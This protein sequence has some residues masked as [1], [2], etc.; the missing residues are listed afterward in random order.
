[1]LTFQESYEKCQTISGDNEAATLVLFKQDINL[2]NKR[3]NAA[4]NNY[5][6]RVSKSAN[7]VADQ[8]YY[9]LPPDCIRVIGV[10]FVLNVDRRMPLRQIRSEYQ[11]RQ[12]NFIQQS[13]NWLVYYFVK[14]ADEVGLYPT[15][16]DNLSNGV[17]IYYEP[18]G[19]ELSQADFT[20]GTVTV[21]NGS[22]TVTHS[23]TDFT[24]SMIGRGFKITDGADGYTYKVA[25]YTSS[26]VITLEEPYIGISGSGRTFK[27]G[28]TFVFPEEYH[29]APTDF[30]LARYFETRN[31][32]DRAKYHMDNFKTLVMDAK[33]KYAS[34]SASQVITDEYDYLNP[35]L[36]NTRTITD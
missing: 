23:G 16:S 8:Q 10:D 24:Q 20:S 22:A 31:N 6:N 19:Y 5:F 17:I 4:I 25:G 29:D 13:S 11:W 1:M 3:F 34:S 12:L 14:G 32:P 18:K 36:D 7:L 28:E 26:S 30:A 27:I 35:W 21:T 2:A 33:E 9:Q 15:P